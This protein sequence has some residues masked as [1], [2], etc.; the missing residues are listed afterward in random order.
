MTRSDMDNGVSLAV[1]S[2]YWAMFIRQSDWTAGQLR[3]AVK[4]LYGDEVDA[5]VAR[6]FAAG[7]IHTPLTTP[8]AERGTP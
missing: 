4:M 6:R 1:A 2:L 5:E 7:Q 8:D 3:E